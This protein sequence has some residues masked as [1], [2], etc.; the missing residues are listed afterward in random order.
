MTREQPFGIQ[1][2][3]SFKRDAIYVE[4]RYNLIGKRLSATASV[5]LAHRED[6]RAFMETENTFQKFVVLPALGVNWEIN[7]KNKIYGTI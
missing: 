2:A 4:P 6:S 3:V 7:S 1:E 5:R